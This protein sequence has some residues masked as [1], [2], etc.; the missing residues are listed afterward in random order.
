[1]TVSVLAAVHSGWSQLDGS[2]WSFGVLMCF[3]SDGL[4]SSHICPLV[5]DVS[6]TAKTCS[7][8]RS[9]KRPPQPQSN[10]K[11]SQ[12]WRRRKRRRSLR[13][14]GPWP[15]LAPTP[16]VGHKS[17]GS[18]DHI[19]FI[20]FT[21]LSCYVQM[22]EHH[23]LQVLLGFC[24]KNEVNV[25]EAKRRLIRRIMGDDSERWHDHILV[26]HL[27]VDRWF[28]EKKLWITALA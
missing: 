9:P 22:W 19:W 18:H 17:T 2:I 4:S 5:S 3:S 8:P 7:P 20:F 21:N 27:N 26:V 14:I 24:G 28:S 10:R 23:S 11:Q 6:R 15:L 12:S 1:M 13:S 25:Y 16:Q